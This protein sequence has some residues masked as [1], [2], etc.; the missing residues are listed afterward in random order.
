MLATQMRLEAQ[1]TEARDALGACRS[2]DS[3]D[4]VAALCVFR[5]DISHVLPRS[6]PAPGSPRAARLCL[7]AAVRAEFEEYLGA[8]FTVTTSKLRRIKLSAPFA[9]WRRVREEPGRRQRLLGTR[10]ILRSSLP[11][12]GLYWC[13]RLYKSRCAAPRGA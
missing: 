1:A 2:R 11:C 10:L 5:C 7:A 12:R 9:A 8:R 4:R 13:T 3:S 6:S